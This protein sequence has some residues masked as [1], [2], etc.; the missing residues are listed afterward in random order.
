V[1]KLLTVK[2]KAVFETMA[3]TADVC[4]CLCQQ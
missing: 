3:T 1:T 4:F 2:L